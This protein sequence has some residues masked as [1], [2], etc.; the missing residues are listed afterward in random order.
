MTMYTHTLHRNLDEFNVTLGLN[1]FGNLLKI[2]CDIDNVALDYIESL[3]Y[4]YAN[5]MFRNVKIYSNCLDRLSKFIKNNNIRSISFDNYTNNIENISDIV[6]FIDDLNVDTI[7]LETIIFDKVLYS[8]PNIRKLVLFDR[9]ETPK[10]DVDFI[11]MF[12]NIKTLRLVSYLS[13]YNKYSTEDICCVIQ[14]STVTKLDCDMSL[15]ETQDTF[16]IKLITDTAITKIKLHFDNCFLH[17]HDGLQKLAIDNKITSFEMDT[18]NFDELDNNDIANILS[19]NTTLIKFTIEESLISNK[20]PPP[21][22][23]IDSLE[24][25]YTI[26]K[27]DIYEQSDT[28]DSILARNKDLH[29][30]RRFNTTKLAN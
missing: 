27:L 26:T 29:N 16:L 20:I 1:Y 7:E 8:L 28:I 6:K 24:N 30:N 2:C 5:V 15:I 23:I 12:P 13:S 3:L 22:L 10:L 11:N 21:Q 19:C 9:L 25:N 14:N 18:V 17:V 4:N